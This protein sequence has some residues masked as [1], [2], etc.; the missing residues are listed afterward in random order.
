MSST[1]GI[2]RDNKYFIQH[3]FNGYKTAGEGLVGNAEV[4]Y[5]NEKYKFEAM[6]G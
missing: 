6:V 5:Y 3:N 1:Q 4:G 2:I